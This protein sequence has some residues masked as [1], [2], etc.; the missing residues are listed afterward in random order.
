MSVKAVGGQQQK[1]KRLHFVMDVS[2]SMYRFNGMDRRL[3]RLL[4]ATTMI[5]ES[6]AGFSQKF[7]VCVV[8][9]FLC[10]CVMLMIM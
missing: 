7:D 1:P 5:M 8:R 10:S 4:D 6:F 2:G 9:T 3:D